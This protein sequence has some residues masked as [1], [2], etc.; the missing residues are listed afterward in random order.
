MRP[1]RRRG[2]HVIRRRRKKVLDTRSARRALSPQNMDRKRETTTLAVHRCRFVDYAPSSIT[3]LAYPPLPLPSL[4]GKKKTTAGKQPSNS[5]S[6]PS[7][8]P[9]ATSISAN[10]WAQTASHSAPKHGSSGRSLRVVLCLRSA[11]LTKLITRPSPAHTHPRST[12]SHS[13]YATQ[14][15]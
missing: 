10:G 12:R 6:S 4:K 5:G 11:N 8:M 7:A 2:G 1:E 3:A 15:I 13:C 9:M 14:T